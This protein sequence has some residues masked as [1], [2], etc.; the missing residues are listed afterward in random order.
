MLLISVIAWVPMVL[1]AIL[2]GILREYWFAKNL[3]ELQAHQLS[4]VT[5]LVLLGIY[6]GTLMLLWKIDSSQQAIAVGLIWICLTIG[7]EFL[8]GHYVMRH[9]WNRLWSD[10]NIFAGRIW[11]AVLLWIGGAPFLFYRLY[12]Q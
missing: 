4:T 11:I 6:I 9:P 10:Y 3:N 12:N 8:F 1:I 2:N 7:F 5:A